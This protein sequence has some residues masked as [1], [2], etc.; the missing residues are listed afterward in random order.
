MVETLSFTSRDRDREAIEAFA[1]YRDLYAGGSPGGG[2]DGLSRA[3]VTGFRYPRMLV[4]DRTLACVSHERDHRRV[5]QDGFDHV[6][7]QLVRSGS[8][9]LSINSAIKVVGVGQIVVSDMTRPQKVWTEGAQTITLAIAR[10]ALG[11]KLSPFTDIHGR[12]LIAGRCGLLVD[13]MVSL[14]ARGKETNLRLASV[15]TDTVVALFTAILEDDETRTT[16]TRVVETTKF[17]QCLTFIDKSLSDPRLSADRIAASVGVSRSV[18]Y[19]LFEPLGGV[20]AFVQQ[21][22]LNAVRRALSRLDEGRP[23]KTVAESYGFVSASHANRIFRQAFGMTPGEFRKE[24]LSQT[25]LQIK[26]ETLDTSEGLFAWHLAEGL[27]AWHPE[28]A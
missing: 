5:A 13:L 11:K 9:L 12:V 15:A 6:A 19:R 27:V 17:D 2:A 8:L 20:A 21:R 26:R 23:Y 25:H 22:R 4:F 14:V 28:P 18:L 24:V 16:P 7:L 10:D 3:E 1:V